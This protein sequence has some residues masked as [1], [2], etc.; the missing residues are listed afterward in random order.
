MKGPI[1]QINPDVEGEFGTAT[2]RHVESHKVYPLAIFGA[3]ARHNLY[4]GERINSCVLFMFRGPDHSPRELLEL[5]LYTIISE[6]SP[7]KP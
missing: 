7:D 6:L 4:S 3:Q 2:R 5:G 1:I